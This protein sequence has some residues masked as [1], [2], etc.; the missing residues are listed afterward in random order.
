[1]QNSTCAERCVLFKTVSIKVNRARA[2]ETGSDFRRMVFRGQLLT[3]CEHVAYFIV[4][5]VD[6]CFC[7]AMRIIG[8]GHTEQTCL[9]TGRTFVYL[10]LTVLRI[11]LQKLLEG[12][13]KHI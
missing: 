3:H 4:D 6:R 13:D 5:D 9:I 8:A 1:M 11:V 7:V 2:E 10:E 12:V